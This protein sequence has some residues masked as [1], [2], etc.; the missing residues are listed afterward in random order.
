[1][2]QPLILSAI[3]W[4]HSAPS[5][6]RNNA[7]YKTSTQTPI[8]VS[9]QTHAPDSMR[10][11]NLQS[12]LTCSALPAGY[13]PATYPLRNQMASLRTVY[14][15]QQCSLRDL[16]AGYA[17]ATYPLRKQT[18]SLSTVYPP[19]QCSLRDF[20]T[21]ANHQ[22]EGRRCEVLLT[23]RTSLKTSAAPPRPPAASRVHR[24]PSATDAEGGYT[25]ERG[26][27]LSAERVAGQAGRQGSYM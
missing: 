17:P 22:S 24:L 1:M 10:R 25:R 8:T 19:Q 16:P 11:W 4:R 6:L 18:A 7:V 5:T 23:S 15:P 2:R 20:H 13:A 14:P 3:R 9:S 27:G 12:I 26:A 21:D